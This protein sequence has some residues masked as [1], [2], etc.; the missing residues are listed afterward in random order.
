VGKT[1]RRA[2]RA[3]LADHARRPTSG[4][5]DPDEESPS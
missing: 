1:S 4:A 3:A 2:L 5:P